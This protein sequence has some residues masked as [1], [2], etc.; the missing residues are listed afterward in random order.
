MQFLKIVCLTIAM[1]ISYGILHDMVTAHLCVEYFTVGHPPVFNTES[2]VMLAFGWGVIATW[3]AGAI[4]GVSL[5]CAARLGP[6]PKRLAS[7]LAKPLFQLMCIMFMIAAAAGAI[8]ALLAA[9]GQLRL[10]GRFSAAVPAERQTLF[11]ADLWAHNASYLSGL[12][13]GL[14]LTRRVWSNRRKL[15]QIA[16]I[17]PDK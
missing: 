9:S 6:Y 13:G 14:V 10:T 3:W 5:A 8:G 4:I 1:A 12:I 16:P 11:L 15:P 2:P 17:A 7:S